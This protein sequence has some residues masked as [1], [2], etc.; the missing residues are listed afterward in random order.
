MTDKQYSGRWVLA[1][2]LLSLF[3]LV[4]C[5]HED[6]PPQH[7]DTTD[8]VEPI[9]PRPVPAR[10]TVIEVG[11]IAFEMIYV[12]GGTFWM[13]AS[14]D[15]SSPN[16]D[17]DSDPMERPLHQVTL[18]PYLIA[19]EEVSQLLFH[20]VMGFNPSQ[21]CDQMLPVHNVSFFNAQDFMDSIFVISHYQ[22]RLPT[23]AEWEYAAKGGG[24]AEENYL[25]AGSNT[26]GDVAW[27]AGNADDRP[28]QCGEMA[29]NALGLFDMSGNLKEWCSDW[30][31]QYGS[32]HQYD[33]ENMAEPQN[34]NQQKR[35]VRGGSFK[36]SPYYLRNTAR[37]FHY[38]S[39]EG[40]DI[41][42]RLVLSVTQ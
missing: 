34:P 30:Y 7:N 9:V 18:S 15:A 6:D 29:P 13:G 1:L 42:F 17:P 37:Q 20:A 16:Y 25:F 31:G 38:P 14:T 33:P 36:Q 4:A 12:P 32:Q 8:I 26:V 41:G 27:Y 3:G 21:I 35:V 39:Y 24:R 5:D 2:L 19:S 10:D 23:E 28:H 22:F 11:G 40:N